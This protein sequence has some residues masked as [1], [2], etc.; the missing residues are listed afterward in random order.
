MT[1]RLRAW[2]RDVFRPI[3]QCPECHLDL[4][5]YCD[6]CRAMDDNTAH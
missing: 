4:S 1:R 5:G 3:G 2:L 6:K